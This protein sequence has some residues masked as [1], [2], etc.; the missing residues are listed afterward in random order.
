MRR[1]FPFLLS[2]FLRRS[3][4][5]LGV[6]F[7]ACIARAVDAP[8]AVPANPGPV[9]A[10]DP[11]NMIWGLVFLGA[12]VAAAWWLIR[13]SGGLQ[14]QGGRG[15]KVIASLALGPR[16]RAVLVEIAGEQWLLGVASG[17]VTL[18]HRFEQ[19][20]ITGGDGEDFASRI[21]AVLQ[22]GMRK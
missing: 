6:G 21:R 17:S 11:M 1:H 13:R 14:L 20:I 2:N 18:L 10:A 4:V 16:E 8:A 12:L 19:P 7:Y 9:I 15:M 22:Q 3:A 5:A